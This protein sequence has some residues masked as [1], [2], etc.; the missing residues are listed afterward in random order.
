LYFPEQRFW[1]DVFCSDFWY[2][3]RKMDSATFVG[4]GF[5]IKGFV[6]EISSS[7]VASR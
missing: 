2:F 5:L 3:G 1:I 6:F 4:S 7:E